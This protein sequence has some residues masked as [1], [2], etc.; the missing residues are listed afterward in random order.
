MQQ[1][2]Y[3]FLF[4]SV[5]II[6]I[7]VWYFTQKDKVSPKKTINWKIPD[8]WRK[9]LSENV[10]FYKNLDKEKKAE[11]EER[12][13]AF[14]N[15]TVITGID[16][17]ID[18]KDKILVASS[19]LIPI[20]AFP[21]W[22]YHTLKEVL[23]YPDSLAKYKEENGVSA[24]EGL[25][26][27]GIYDKKIL[28]S[29]PAL[30]QGFANEGDKQNVGIHEF[31][32]LVD[33][34]DGVIDGLPAVLMEKKYALPWIDHVHHK[35]VK[36]RNDQAKDIRDY[37]GANKEEFFAVAGE[38]FFEQP[39]QLRKKHPALYDDLMQIFHQDLAETRNFSADVKQ[40]VGRNDLCPCGSGKK[41]K[42]CCEE[43]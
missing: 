11:F 3:V 40:K 31:L 38:Y 19:A 7:A 15:E 4:I 36:V 21:K 25:V 42:H 24:I 5:T 10:L 23:L 20:F 16:T 32:H 39:R 9:F 30:H 26:G 2:L 37:A 6:L 43:R 18:Y 17:E 1:D 13:V 8:E 12:M 27:S 33:K 34:E 22:R 14:L 41:F 29:K 28:F 35:L